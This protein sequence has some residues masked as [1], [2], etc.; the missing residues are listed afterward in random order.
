MKNRKVQKNNKN[1]I[2]HQK[3]LKQKSM[4]LQAQEKDLKNNKIEKIIIKK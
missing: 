1:L 3:R 4:E 2:C